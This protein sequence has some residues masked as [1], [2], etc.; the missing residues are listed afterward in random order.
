MRELRRL[1]A[2]GLRYVPDL[3]FMRNIS[4]L[5]S[6]ILL[7]SACAIFSGNKYEAKVQRSNIL[8]IVSED[9]SP[10]LSC[11]GDEVIK[12][13]NL[14]KIAEN[15]WLFKNAYVTQSVCSPSRSSILTGLYP[16]QNGH[17]GLATQG[18]QFVGHVRNIY[19]LL[20][21]AGYRTGMI[22]KLHLNPASDFPIDYHPI[23]GPNYEKLDM[24][25]YAD[26]ASQFM[27]ASDD[28]FFLMVNLPDA[29]WPFQD[30]VEGRPAMPVTAAQVKPFPYIGFD[31]EL[32]RRYTT[33]IYNCLLRLDECIGELTTSLKTSGKENNTLVIYL[34]DH[35]DE[36]ARGKFDI[37]EVSNKVPF[38]VSWPGRISK[39]VRSDA[40]VSAVDIVPTLLEAAGVHERPDKLAGQSLFP[41]FDNPSVQFREYLFTEKNA[42]QVSLYYPRR[43]VRDSMYKLIYTLLPDRKNPVAEGYTANTQRAEPLAGSPTLQE[44]EKAPAGIQQVYY[45]W[46]NP[47]AIQL[48]DLHNDP[49]EFNDLSSNP[50]HADVKNRLLNALQNWQVETDDPLRFPEKLKML[51][52]EHDTMKV[53][54]EM[55]WQYPGYLYGL[56]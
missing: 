14:D 28:P 12:T 32:I 51:T 48:Y 49:H 46:I 23:K 52:A 45:S 38:L 17:I 5:C 47:P 19:S 29:H 41:L 30:V 36:M 16:H 39:G 9:H 50:Q 37:Y 11:Y 53:S 24:K 22:G 1:P 6:I 8:L 40:L 55:K 20:K 15:G 54:K 33:S 2:S 56:K 44:L 3:K 34:S 42:D 10:H 43:A 35:G 31:N 13:P 18:Y 7:L 25:R 21:D 27:N 26:Y 4:I